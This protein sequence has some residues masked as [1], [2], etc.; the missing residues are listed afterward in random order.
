MKRNLLYVL[1][2]IGASLITLFFVRS[3]YAQ[4]ASVPAFT[5]QYTERAVN[6]TTNK[7][8]Y[9]TGTFAHRSDGSAARVDINHGPTG[10]INVNRVIASVPQQRRTV[11]ADAVNVKTTFPWKGN[12]S[13]LQYNASDATCGATAEEPVLGYG[14][15][16][17]IKVVKLVRDSG[18]RRLESWRAPSLGCY[19]LWHHIDFR[20]DDGTVTDYSEWAATGIVMGEPNAELFQ[21]PQD[22]KEVKPSEMEQAVR[23]HFGKECT[24]CSNAKWKAQDDLYQRLRTSPDS[25]Q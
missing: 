11:V 9:K 23:A 4:S 13:Q 1:L 22:Y 25:T 8:I 21:E 7:T 10:E 24:E 19:V 20:K 3:H 18:D 17:G 2:A 6:Y 5:V 12:A 15:F 14:E 16:L